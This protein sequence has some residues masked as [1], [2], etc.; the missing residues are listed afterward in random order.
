VSPHRAKVFSLLPFLVEGALT[1]KNFVLKM[2]L[3][4]NAELMR[5]QVLRFSGVQT[6]YVPVNNIVP[7]TKYDYWG[8]SWRLWFK[9]H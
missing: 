1:P 2:E 7:I 8:A 6:V 9:Q 5:L 3:F 4:P